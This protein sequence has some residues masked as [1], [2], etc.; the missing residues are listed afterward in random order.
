VP[1]PVLLPVLVLLR[2]D[3]DVEELVLLAVL[4]LDSAQGGGYD[5]DNGKVMVTRDDWD[6][7]TIT[8]AVKGNNRLP[9]R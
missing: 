4:E 2:D 9:Y 7:G 6:K 5:H 3:V 8:H 1:V